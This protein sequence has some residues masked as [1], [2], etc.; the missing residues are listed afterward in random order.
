[1]RNGTRTRFADMHVC[2]IR[3]VVTYEVL[4]D[5]MVRALRM[6]LIAGLHLTPCFQLLPPSDMIRVGLSLSLGKHNNAGTPID[7]SKVQHS[8]C[9][10]LLDSQYLIQILFICSGNLY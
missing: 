2:E 1:M 3:N 5:L 10:A 4:D 7:D 9:V 8:S 6:I